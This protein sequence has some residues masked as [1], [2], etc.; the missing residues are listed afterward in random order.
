MTEWLLQDAVPLGAL[1]GLADANDGTPEAVLEEGGYDVV[2]HLGG[3]DPL[4]TSGAPF[5]L[6]IAWREGLVEGAEPPEP[7][8]VRWTPTGVR[9]GRRCKRR[10]R[11]GRRGR[12]QDE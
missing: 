11:R 3:S 5:L 2:M 7:F 10:R 4:L 9:R 6:T 1:I 12:R 8:W